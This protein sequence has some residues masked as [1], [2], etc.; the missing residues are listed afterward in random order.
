MNRYNNKEYYTNRENYITSL[1]N[2]IVA[3][4]DHNIKSIAKVKELKEYWNSPERGYIDSDEAF[5]KVLKLFGE[6]WGN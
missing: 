4:E 3:W 1:Q 2:K 6:E 5:D